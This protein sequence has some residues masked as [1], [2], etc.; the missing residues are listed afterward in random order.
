MQL[1]LALELLLHRLVA[2]DVR[3]PADAVS[4]QAAVLRRP[5]QMW[6]HRLQSVETVIKVTQGVAV[7]GDDNSFLIRRQHC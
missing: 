3:M 7:E 1:R 6:N 2:L 4:L 5:C